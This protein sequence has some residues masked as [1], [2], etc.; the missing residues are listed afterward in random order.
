M[1]KMYNFFVR[2]CKHESTKL[3]C[4]LPCTF[5]IY[6][7]LLPPLHHN[8]KGSAMSTESGWYDW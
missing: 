4:M 5:S 1:E 7:L 3:V 8:S 2:S 6:C